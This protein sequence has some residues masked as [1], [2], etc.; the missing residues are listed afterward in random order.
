M[1]LGGLG[2][3]ILSTFRVLRVRFRGTALREDLVEVGLSARLKNQGRRA[4]HRRVDPVCVRTGDTAVGCL[5]ARTQ[6][7][8]QGGRA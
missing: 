8:A 3:C 4:I 2:L 1:D 5:C 7:A 6:E